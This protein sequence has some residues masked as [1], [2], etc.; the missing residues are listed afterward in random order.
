MASVEVW[1]ADRVSKLVARAVGKVDLGGAE[2]YVCSCKGP[3]I[4]SEAEVNGYYHDGS[5]YIGV[6]RLVETNVADHDLPDIGRSKF[7]VVQSDGGPS[8]TR[9]RHQGKVTTFV[10]K[11][12]FLVIVACHSM[13]G[14][15]ALVACRQAYQIFRC[16]RHT[17]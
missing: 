12:N 10:E 17:P 4:G 14:C 15:W 9:C 16:N 11:H 7:P 2:S 8:L 1:P 5:E 3:G 6:R 13:D